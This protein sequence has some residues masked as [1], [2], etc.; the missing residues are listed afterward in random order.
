MNTS[1]YTTKSLVPPDHRAVLRILVALGLAGFALIIW[2]LLA[3]VF[4][5]T[6]FGTTAVVV[7]HPWRT[8]RFG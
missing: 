3:P 6:L 5:P 4:W 1:G 7:A 8:D 2:G